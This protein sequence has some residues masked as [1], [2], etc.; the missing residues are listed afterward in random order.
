MKAGTPGP[1]EVLTYFLC[2]LKVCCSFE[3]NF[4]ILVTIYLYLIIN[5]TV[6]CCSYIITVNTCIN[7]LKNIF[8]L[9]FRHAFTFFHQYS[10]V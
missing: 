3:Y 2:L 10:V 5:C 6:F 7:R 4:T 1:G 9:A 8:F